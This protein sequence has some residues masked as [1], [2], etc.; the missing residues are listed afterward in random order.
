MGLVVVNGALFILMKDVILGRAALWLTHKRGGLFKAL[1]H[2]PFFC[3]PVW[4]SGKALG[5]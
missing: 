1:L 2:E 5:W 4:P 3:E